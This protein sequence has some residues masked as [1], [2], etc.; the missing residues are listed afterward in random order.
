[1]SEQRRQ[2]LNELLKEAYQLLNDLERQHLTSS[3]PKERM[4]LRNDIAETKGKIMQYEEELNNLGAAG[5][6][7]RQTLGQSP[8]FTA[9]NSQGAI[10]QVG[11]NVTQHFYNGLHTVTQ[12]GDVKMGD[13]IHIGN[14]TNSTVNVKA[15]LD[16]V[17]QTVQAM[18]TGSTQDKKQLE[19]LIE[20]LKSQLAAVPA[21]HSQ[22]VE[23]VSESLEYAVQE[24][25]RDQPDPD[26]VEE[27][28]NKIVKAA[29]NVA[30]VA[31]QVG[32]PI[33]TTV[34]A[35]VSLLKGVGIVK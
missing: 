25:K 6:N 19:T 30:K 18:P 14:I 11:G 34:T 35:I 23:R 29:Q 7:S 27:R 16:H 26:E 10:G 17:K 21:E 5:S 33:V 24:V 20:Q 13:E 1:M 4:G 8:N 28:S 3:N 12:K 9:P 31:G 2:D 22:A 15:K 32:G